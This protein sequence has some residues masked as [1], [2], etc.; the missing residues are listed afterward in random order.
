MT[1]VRGG[2]RMNFKGPSSLVRAFDLLVTIGAI[3]GSKDGKALNVEIWQPI[4]LELRGQLAVQILAQKVVAGEVATRFRQ[5]PFASEQSSGFDKD[6]TLRARS[7]FVSS[8]WVFSLNR[9]AGLSE[10]NEKRFG[11]CF[12]GWVFASLMEVWVLQVPKSV[13][14]SSSS[15]C[16]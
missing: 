10:E 11:R 5:A 6:L 9:E 12:E 14:A 4:K 8:S 13:G 15:N 16:P 7:A 3:I 2:F 1:I